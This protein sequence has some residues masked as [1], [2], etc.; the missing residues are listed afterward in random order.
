M[1]FD[2]VI[3]EN[4]RVANK[5]GATDFKDIDDQIRLYLV[6]TKQKMPNGQPVYSCQV[7]DKKGHRTSITNHI[8]SY[9]IEGFAQLCDD[10]E[11]SLKSRAVRKLHKCSVKKYS[12][13]M[14]NTI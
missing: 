10:C 6:R 11:K 5:S 2:N 9:H 3:I 1:V 7:C 4:V 8:E 14:D 12:S 13:L